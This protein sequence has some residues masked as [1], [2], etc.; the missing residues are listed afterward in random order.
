VVAL[1][2][3]SKIAEGSFEQVQRHPAV[4]EAYLGKRAAAHA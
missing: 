2:H 3:G 4:L 1:D